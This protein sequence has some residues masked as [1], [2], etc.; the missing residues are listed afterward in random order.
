M[1]QPSV[2]IVILNWNGKHYLQQFLPSVLATSYSNLRIVVADNGSADDSIAFLKQ[3]FPQVEVIILTKN[4]GFAK[5]Y[6]E[7][8]KQVQADYY[9]L[10][11]S[12][13]DVTPGWL[14]PMVDL[15]EQDA[16]NAACQP[17]ILSF[18][19]KAFF[20]YAGACGGWLDAYGYPFA[21]GRIF[22]FC[23][24]DKHQFDTTQKIFWATG[25]AMLIRTSVYHTA[26]RF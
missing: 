14:T 22:D 8:L 1:S 23:E 17:K 19:D 10:L 2:A 6:N 18:K 25:A 13:V 5:G 15:L 16:S 20:E 12:D 11:N 7:A 4:F 9:L 24:E 21:K 26:G 3:S